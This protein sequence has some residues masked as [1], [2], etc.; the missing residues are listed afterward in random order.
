MENK[1]DPIFFVWAT[2]DEES[3]RIYSDISVLAKIRDDGYGWVSTVDG[4]AVGC[5]TS[6]P[7]PD[8][9][10][11]ALLYYAKGMGYDK[12]YIGRCTI[13]EAVSLCREYISFLQSILNDA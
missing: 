2:I 7:L 8:S 6:K 4:E 5:S 1:K 12:E 11:D 9:Q 3:E 13:D 10:A